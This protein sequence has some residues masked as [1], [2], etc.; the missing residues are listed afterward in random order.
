MPVHGIVAA[1]LSLSLVLTYRS[2]MPLQVVIKKAG[3]GAGQGAKK[4]AESMIV[5]CY[6]TN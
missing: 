5:V 4:R 3:A 2:L 1:A 6:T